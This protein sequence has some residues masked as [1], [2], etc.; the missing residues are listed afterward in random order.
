MRCRR[1]GGTR[2]AQLCAHRRMLYH[3]GGCGTAAEG[4]G[5]HPAAPRAVRSLTQ[6]RRTCLRP[7]ADTASPAAPISLP[8]APLHLAPL[9]F[10]PRRT[11]VHIFIRSH[12]YHNT[13][14]I[15]V[16]VDLMAVVVDLGLT[17]G[18]TTRCSK[19]LAK[20]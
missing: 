1:G 3:M 16:C 9:L 5:P 8:G 15:L 13:V 6:A 18:E 12:H 19:R 4:T 10:H 7:P 14:I 20:G 17:L 2:Q 11:L